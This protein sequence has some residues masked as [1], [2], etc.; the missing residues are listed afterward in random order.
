MKDNRKRIKGMQRLVLF[1]IDH[2]Y[3]SL[4]FKEI[5]GKLQFC[6]WKMVHESFT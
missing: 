5:Y 1:D 6:G 2:R 3:L 4:I